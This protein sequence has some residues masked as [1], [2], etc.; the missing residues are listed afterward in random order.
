MPR[1][2]CRSV[3]AV[4]AQ[5][6]GTPVGERRPMTCVKRAKDKGQRT[7]DKGQRTKDKGQSVPDLAVGLGEGAHEFLKRMILELANPLACKT[8]GL[9]DLPQGHGRV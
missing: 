2:I 4:S 5:L 6:S 7:K 8:Q 3:R 1:Q 9:T